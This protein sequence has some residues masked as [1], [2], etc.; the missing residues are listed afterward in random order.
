[1]YYSSTAALVCMLGT[2][3]APWGWSWIIHFL[4][5]SPS[6]ILF[7]LH[8]TGWM[9]LPVAAL[10]V[11]VVSVSFPLSLRVIILREPGSSA[12]T[13]NDGSFEQSLEKEQARNNLLHLPCS[14]LYCLPFASHPLSPHQMVP[15]SVLFVSFPLSLLR[16]QCPGAAQHWPCLDR[17]SGGCSGFCHLVFNHCSGK[18]PGQ[19]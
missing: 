17:R 5:P 18:I 14:V 3:A 9:F 12:L 13:A 1:M 16:S 6:F 8:F 4:F 15:S 10:C 19:A 7:F 11:S 2:P